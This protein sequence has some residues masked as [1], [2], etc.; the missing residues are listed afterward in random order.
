MK[1]NFCGNKSVRNFVSDSFF[2]FE[3]SPKNA[4]RDCVPF[5]YCWGKLFA[6]VAYAV[7]NLFSTRAGSEATQ[8]FIS[9]H[10]FV[11]T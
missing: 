3:T 10:Y 2:T 9:D 5:P 8:I 11:T 6:Y 7:N 1:S 4:I